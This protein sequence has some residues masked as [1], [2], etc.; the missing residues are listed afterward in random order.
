[1]AA[2]YT[3][4]LCKP[5]SRMLPGARGCRLRGLYCTQ[6]CST[7]LSPATYGRPARGLRLRTTTTACRGRLTRPLLHATMASRLWQ[8]HERS[9][10]DATARA[11]GQRMAWAIDSVAIAAAVQCYR[12]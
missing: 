8:T 3:R 5:A 7:Q 9:P 10:L 2:A 11:T 12:R 6:W 4:V 1:M